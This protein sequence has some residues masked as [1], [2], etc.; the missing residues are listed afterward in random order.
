MEAASCA[1]IQEFPSI[2]WNPKVHYC[3]HKSSALVLILS[4]IIPPPKKK[5]R[6]MSEEKNMD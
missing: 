5:N 1:A 2:I 3:V 6:C 4:Q